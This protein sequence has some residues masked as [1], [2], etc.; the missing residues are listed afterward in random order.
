MAWGG[1]SRG[2]KSGRE[3]VHH[4]GQDCR[5][6]KEADWCRGRPR[7]EAAASFLA[8]SWAGALGI[9]GTAGRAMC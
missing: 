3:E 2:E 7:G 9:L 6:L 5:V 8:S 1:G 4:E